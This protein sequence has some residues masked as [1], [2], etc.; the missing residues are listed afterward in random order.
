MLLEENGTVGFCGSTVGR[1]IARGNAQDEEEVHHG[2]CY[3]LDR[4]GHYRE[5]GFF[6]PERGDF[7]CRVQARSHKE[8][9]CANAG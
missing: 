9:E 2:I 5:W 1:K 3:E 6:L 8:D 7:S 4:R